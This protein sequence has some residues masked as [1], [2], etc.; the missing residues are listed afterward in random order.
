MKNHEKFI[1]DNPKSQISEAFRT[2]RTNIQFL[3]IDR[4]LKSVVIT[5]SIPEEGKSTI[6]VNIA[7]SMAQLDKKILLIDCDLRKPVLHKYFNLNNR[8]GLTN[9]LAKKEDFKSN[10]ISVNEIVGLDILPSGPVPPNPSE[11]LSSKSM[12]KFLDSI[13][14]D[15]DLIIIDSPPVGVVSDSTIL[16]TLVDGTILVVS[17]GT[18]DRIQVIRSKEQLEQVDAN[19]LGTILNKIPIRKDQ[20]YSYYGDNNY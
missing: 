20:Q 11:L 14:K 1:L 13:D 17:A 19:I 8:Q 6:A 5:S 18:T 12:E 15:Y 10:I 7:I 3:D 9:I 2:L 16:S 4:D